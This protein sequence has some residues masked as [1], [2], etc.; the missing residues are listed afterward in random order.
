MSTVR[1]AHDGGTY[2]FQRGTR[3]EGRWVCIS[4]RC[5]G[6]IGQHSAGI[7][8][9][10]MHEHELSTLAVAA[11]VATREDLARFLPKPEPEPKVKRQRSSKPKPRRSTGGVVGGISLAG[12]LGG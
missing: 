7:M 2:E 10:L 6:I 5:V 12:L 4:G 1:F 11:G 8:V 3:G 9:P